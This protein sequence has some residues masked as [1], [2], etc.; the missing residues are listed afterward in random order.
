M[1]HLAL[2]DLAIFLKGEVMIRNKVSTVIGSRRLTIA[3]TARLA[4][5]GY[6][7]I[8]RLYKGTTKRI[9]MDT[10][11]KLCLVLECQVSDL[12]EYVPDEEPTA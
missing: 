11:D 9:D 10:L 1:N 5:T 6:N 4:G 3:D 8:E 7:T 2:N 12:F